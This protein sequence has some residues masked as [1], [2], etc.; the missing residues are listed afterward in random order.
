[1]L[2]LCF[3]FSSSCIPYVVSFSGFFFILY[4][5]C[6]QF[7]CVFLHL[8]YPYVVSF[9]GFFLHLV[10]PMLSVS[11]GC[12][13]LIAPSV[14][15]N[16]YL[17]S[18]LPNNVLYLAFQTFWLWAYLINCIAETHRATYI[19]YITFFYL[20]HLPFFTIA[21]NKKISKLCNIKYS[22]KK[23]V[24]RQNTTNQDVQWQ[25]KKQRITSS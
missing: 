11:L 12:P 22:I 10:Y 25:L 19:R 15:S 4:T 3:V 6:C 18:L 2:C 14:F 17:S 8:V 9:S 13:F 24:T 23:H 21:K 7:L 5:L 16:V 20:F 1:M